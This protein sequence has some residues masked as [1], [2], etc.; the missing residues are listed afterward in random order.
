MMVNFRAGGRLSRY[1][2]LA[3]FDV[4]HILDDRSLTRVCRTVL[5]RWDLQGHSWLHLPPALQ[6]EIDAHIHITPHVELRGTRLIEGFFDPA[7][8]CSTRPS[9]SP[10]LRQVR[11]RLASEF[12]QDRLAEFVVD[13]RNSR[14]IK[15]AFGPHQNLLNSEAHPIGSLTVTG[16]IAG[17]RGFWDH[18]RARRAP[19]RGPPFLVTLHDDANTFALGFMA[20]LAFITSGGVPDM[21]DAGLARKYPRLVCA[22]STR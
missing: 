7:A 2:S 11:S 20:A 18:E 6:S 4:V 9:I 10:L 17:S 19:L 12:P 5:L 16:R 21:Q 1:T 14:D 22:V 8:R 15:T 13:C 3:F